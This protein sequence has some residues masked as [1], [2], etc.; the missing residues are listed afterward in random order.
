MSPLTQKLV[1]MTITC[2]LSVMLIMTVAAAKPN[3]VHGQSSVQAEAIERAKL[4]SGPGVTYAQVG[5]IVK[6]T[7][8]PVIGRS[9]K[10]PWLLLQLPDRQGW[11]FK[12]LVKLTGDINTVPVTEVILDGTTF[13]TTG[14]GSPAAGATQTVVIVPFGSDQTG[15]PTPTA[16]VQSTPL[17]VNTPTPGGPTPLVVI[18]TDTPGANTPT[19]AVVAVEPP[20][21]T[22]SPTVIPATPTPTRAV[23]VYAEAKDESYVRYGPGTDFDRIGTIRKGTLYAVLRRHSRFEK[24]I[25]IAYADVAGGRGWVNTELMNITGDLQSVPTT[26]DTAFN[27][28]TLTPTPQMVITSVAPW[29]T[30]PA[31]ATSMAAL[32]TAAGSRVGKSPALQDVGVAVYNYLLSQGFEPR[33]NKQASVFLMD[34][35]TGEAYVANDNVAY[36]GVS[37]MKIPVLISLYRKIGNAPTAEQAQ[38]MAEMIICSENLSS[39]RL[40]AMMGDGDEYRGTQYVTETM[41][42]LGLKNTF[43]ARSFFTGVKTS[44][45]TPTEQPFAPPTIVADQQQTQ[46]DPS[47]QSTPADMGWLL[48]S[49]YQCAETGSGILPATFPGKIDQIACRRMLRVLAGDKLGAMIQAGVPDSV[50]VAHKH[51]WANETHG[52]VGIVY[53]PGGNYVLAIMLYNKTWLNYKDSF[54]TIAEASRLVYNAYNPAAPVAQTNTRPVDEVCTIDTVRVKDPTLMNDLVAVNPPPVK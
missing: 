18:I 5:E 24:W 1:R 6:G 52:D 47:N 41:Q 43:L 10:F 48:A 38:L 35:Q 3:I 54:P 20:T 29:A 36:S 14:A 4:R 46:P 26:S 32:A 40:L 37:L 9:A 15:T 13:P 7:Q 49:M 30:N 33:T 23:T 45:P 22:P 27:N 17:P 28:P 50:T 44:G 39:N 2:T 8:Y 16:L 31:Q 19:S 53:S 21:L 34:L 25:E 51:G 12:D 11:V 42:L